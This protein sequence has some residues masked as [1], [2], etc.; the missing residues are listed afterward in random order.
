M[1]DE[2]ERK[3]LER[4]KEQEELVRKLKAAKA[5]DV[6]VWLI[7]YFFRYGQLLFFFFFFTNFFMRLKPSD[8]T[9]W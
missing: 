9:F 4:V 1:A 2:I 8:D 7:I 5:N 6:Q 3:L